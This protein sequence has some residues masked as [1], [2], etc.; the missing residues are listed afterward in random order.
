MLSYQ[1]LVSKAFGFLASLTGKD[2]SLRQSNLESA[3]GALLG[4]FGADNFRDLI[5]ESI[6]RLINEPFVI[7][8]LVIHVC[9]MHCWNFSFKN[10][11]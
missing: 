9:C 10:Q 3:T 5:Q 8:F 7:L 6:K 2:M 11:K 1:F 4:I